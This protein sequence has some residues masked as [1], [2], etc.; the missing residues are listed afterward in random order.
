ME[1]RNPDIESLD[2]AL[3]YDASKYGIEVEIELS[4]LFPCVYFMIFN[5]KEEIDLY[6]MAG[7][8][9]EIHGLLSF[10]VKE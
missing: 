4:T 8:F 6:K 5:T 3:K 10:H 2:A 7:R 9:K 1:H